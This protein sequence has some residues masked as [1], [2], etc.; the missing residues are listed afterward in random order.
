MIRDDYIRTVTDVVVIDGDTFRCTVD[1]GFWVQVRMSCRLAGLNAPE[2]RDP[3]GAESTAALAGLLTDQDVTVRS[4]R[5]DK[6]AGRFDAQ[7]YAGAVHV[8]GWLVDHGFAVAWDGTGP[9]PVVPWPPVV[10]P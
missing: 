7:V 6:F 2:R 1:L 5:P 9:R 4:V 3:G 10:T 8:N